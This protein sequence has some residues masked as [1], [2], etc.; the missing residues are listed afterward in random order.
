MSASATQTTLKLTL[1]DI[2]RFV[3]AGTPPETELHG[4]DLS[5]YVAFCRLDGALVPIADRRGKTL[6]FRSR[7]RAL[8]A[9]ANTGLEALEFVHQSVYAEMIG[10]DGDRPST[11][12]RERLR[13]APFADA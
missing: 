5:I 2:R 13:L 10:V 8:R 7:E 6:Q 11:E 4:V 12:M 3:K 9:L 1:S